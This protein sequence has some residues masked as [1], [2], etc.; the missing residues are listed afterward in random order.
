LKYK[1]LEAV[2]SLLSNY[3]H[4]KEIKRVDFN[5]LRAEF[6][7]GFI[8][9]FSL[10]KES[11]SIFQTDD[12]IAQNIPQA[13]FD[14]ILGR[15]FRRA[16]ISI[17]I[18]QNDKVLLIRSSIQGA[19]KVE[20]SILRL[21]FIPRNSNALILDENNIVLEALRHSSKEGSDREIVV[22]KHLEELPPPPFVFSKDVIEGF[23]VGEFL[24]ENYKKKIESTLLQKRTSALKIA[25]N[26]ERKLSTLLES[27][28][29]E[30]ELMLGAK[31]LK[32]QA[33]AILAN[34]DRVNIHK[35][36]QTLI[37]HY[38]ESI[39]VELPAHAKS[40]VNAADIL[41]GKA[42][43]MEKKA[44]NIHIQ[45]EDIEAKLE[46]VKKV[47][48]NIK[49]AKNLNEIEILTQKQS[50]K[51]ERSKERFEAFFVENYKI[52]V[53]RNQKENKEL[54]EQSKSDDIWFHIRDIPSC[55][56]IIKTDKKEPP[57]SVL[58][59]AAKLCVSFS[60]DKKGDYEVDYTKRKFVKPK[61]GANVLYNKYKTVSVRKE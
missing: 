24:R 33:D 23:D 4:L 6:E 36:A 58:E 14:S 60:T 10:Q 47:V 20:H 5:I 1:E 27:L 17:E 34:L 13:P 2:A 56:V 32:K 31:N 42:K 39:D 52:I 9:Y 50:R 22:G 45:R 11:P 15:R 16:N 12:D 46:F 53:G 40:V 25:Q 55:H 43:R 38:G 19:Y 44:K 30:N 35:T 41:F 8:I 49:N 57:L 29:S 59:K 51:R 61:E 26:K 7:K 21:E 3:K 28:E 48:Y 54:L 37:N 18:A